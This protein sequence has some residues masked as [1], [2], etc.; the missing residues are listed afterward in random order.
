MADAEGEGR[1]RPG[2][3]RPP[4]RGCWS[5]PGP[6]QAAAVAEALA[7]GLG[8]ALAPHRSH[9]PGD[10]AAL[11]HAQRRLLL[12]QQQ[13]G[14]TRAHGPG[15]AEQLPLQAWAASVGWGASG[16]AG[17]G[18]RAATL[19]GQSAWVTVR[20]TESVIPSGGDCV[21]SCDLCVGGD[22][23]RDCTAAVTSV[24]G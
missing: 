20:G 14:E 4:A 6:A 15:S 3:A 1:A 5:A 22:F 23:P 21:C 13:R 19:P 16:P 17:E 12:G 18:P 8:G 2:S 24:W 11:A 10:P 9:G 7:R